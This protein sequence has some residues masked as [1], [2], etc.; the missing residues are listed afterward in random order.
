MSVATAIITLDGQPLP[1]SAVV[2]EL[3]VIHEVGKISEACLT[4]VDG[5]PAI[6]NF[7]LSDGAS[8]LPGVEVEITLRY[9]GT[10]DSEH[11]VFKGVI[12]RHSVEANQNGGFLKLVI[13]DA[14]IK[15]T[16]TRKKGVYNDITDGDLFT[17]LIEA[18]SLEVGEV[19]TTTL[20]HPELI[21]YWSSDWDMLLSRAD[22]LGYW[23]ITDQGTVSVINPADIDTASATYRFEYG[24]DEIFNFRFEANAELQYDA[25]TATGWNIAEQV[26]AVDNNAESYN[27]NPGDI[28][29]TDLAAITG[30]ESLELNSATPIL[31]EE[32]VE[33]ANGK[34]RKTRTAMIAGSLTTRGNSVIKPGEVMEL[35]G[36][37]AH[38][39]GNAIISG[40]RHR[41]NVNG[42]FT[43]LQ[44]GLNP[45]PFNERVQVMEQPAAGLLPAVQGLQIGKVE[46]FE[47]DPLGELRVKVKIPA[48]GD[49]AGA[50]WAR[51]ASP[52]AGTERGWFFRPEPEDEVILGF[53][54]DDPRFPVILGA[55]FSSSIAQPPDGTLDENNYIKGIFTKTGLKIVLDDENMAVAITT[56]GEQTVAINDNEGTINVA[57]ANGNMI[58]LDS[59]GITITSGGDM[60]FEASG[61]VV[62]K[63][64]EVDVQ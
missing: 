43:D 24:V 54:N 17:Q 63:G 46:A 62:I 1:A 61:K 13:K 52:D 20:E 5:N 36:V 12:V 29:P 4:L 11:V 60:T 21:Q 18:N 27:P 25:I 32:L 16:G 49:E 42:W 28:N 40:V 55:M 56:P 44:F 45:Q 19:V 15:M 8:F 23:V 39:N 57:D 41:M 51:L 30:G 33:W 47:E 7:P 38:F 53:F 22:L 9:E 50:V 31:A 3:D 64:S 37:S 26:L 2:T 48:L 10:P 35:A 34:M 58:V 59:N 6:K 14:A